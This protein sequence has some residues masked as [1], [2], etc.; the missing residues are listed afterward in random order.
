MD[1]ELIIPENFAQVEAGVF[2]SSFPRSKNTAFLKCLKLKSVV[3]LVLEDYPTALVDFYEKSGTELITQGIEG[4]KGAFKEI[5]IVDFNACMR[6][7]MDESKRP[8]L[9]HCN[10]GKHRTGCIVGCIRRLRGWAISAIVDEYMLFAFPKPRQEDQRFIEAFSCENFHD[11]V[12]AAR[13]EG[14]DDKT[15]EGHID[16]SEI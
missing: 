16:I 8:L 7:V 10:K 15:A 14:I 11:S 13:E 2:R 3:S 6:T 12:Q 5:N 1:E 9:I 4:N